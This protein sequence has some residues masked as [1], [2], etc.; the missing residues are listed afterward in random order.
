MSQNIF[1]PRVQTANRVDSL[2]TVFKQWAQVLF[3][4]ALLTLPVV[5][6]SLPTI[7]VNAAKTI[8]I[9]V[10]LYLVLILISLALL[11]SGV[12]RLTF[13]LVLAIWWLFTAITLI[14]ALASPDS[15]AALVGSSLEVYTAGF[16]LVLA[17]VMSVM[18][19]Y[20]QA[21]TLLV[22]T[23][24]ALGLVALVLH[25]W[26]VARFFL[27][28][29]FLNFGIFTTNAITPVGGLNDFALFS[30]LTLVLIIATA[31]Q[32][33]RR[34][35]SSLLV[36]LL[37]VLSLISLAVINFYLVFAALAFGA[38]LMFLYL[39]S[40]DTWLRSDSE[41]GDVEV[42][43]SRFAL[44]LTAVI[45][46][47]SGMFVVSGDYLGGRISTL[48]NLTYLE[49]R[50]SV[51]ATLDIM[52]AVYS[53][54]ALL[55]TGPNHFS[56]AW[57]QHKDQVINQT[58][59]WNTDFSTGS[60]YVPTLVVTLGLFAALVLAVF[61][62]YVFYLGYRTLILSRHNQRDW[63]RVAAISFVA[64][65]YLWGMAL[66]YSPG[67][68]ILIFTAAATGILITAHGVVVPRREF[69]LDVARQRQ[70]GFLLITVV[71]VLIVGSTLALITI[72]K[73]WRA[74]HDYS[75]ALKELS[76]TG[77]T[78]VFDAELERLSNLSRRDQF[79]A[80]RSRFKLV[81]LNR[82][83]LLIEPT[84]EDRSKFEQTFREAVQLAEEAIRRDSNNPFNYALLGSVY[85]VINPVSFVD[86]GVRSQQA[87]ARAR[88]LDPVNPEYY[89]LEAE[90]KNRFGEV[91]AAQ[92][93]L[94]EAIAL[95]P[96]Y[97]TALFL[98]SQID[99]AQ[100]NLDSALNRAKMIV[101]IE[102]QNAARH[103][104][105]GLLQS[106][107]GNSVEAKEAYRAALMIDPGYANARYL[108]ALSMIESG[109]TE[110]ALTELKR[111]YETN[112]D[113]ADL[114]RLIRE[115]EAGTEV[116]LENFNATTRDIISPTPSSQGET[117]AVVPETNLLTPVNRNNSGS[118][119]NELVG[120]ENAEFIE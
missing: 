41:T 9:V 116:D 117:T 20:S 82:L 27:G 120:S 100:G 110:T 53:D 26:Q 93:L 30:G 37:A 48:T 54:S 108:L 78:A 77:N 98:Q 43:V 109:E 36:S 10:A 45:C 51:G 6:W 87:F 70:L 22:R 83:L 50:P 71:L 1:S 56:D 24:V 28:P 40:K 118:G 33:A 16:T 99:I 95:K 113:N 90:I 32:S 74:Q 67:P 119:N 112:T 101:S 62:L 12:I 76:T 91:E 102:P 64:V 3:L 80:E 85:G 29:E 19:I 57:R 115:V 65:I 81:E 42:P 86:A 38:L 25:V 18:L 11:R 8:F 104:Q 79:V 46:L 59:F 88:D 7:G 39:L 47:V 58:L 31:E 63:Y 60:G 114:L 23:F 69:L 84:E 111:V 61:L 17:L 68:L 44:I 72:G 94:E 14:S 97:T 89:V 105:L 2:S 21:Q 96:D 55:G 73:E 15:F 13:P 107:K 35:W 66:V 5:F 4:A 75:L 49:V 106:A 34:L 92:G 103:F 52:K